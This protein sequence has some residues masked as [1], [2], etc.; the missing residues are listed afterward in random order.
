MSEE[1]RKILHM[2]AEG[3]IT[4]EEAERLLSVLKETKDRAH[5]FRVRVYD[6]NNGKTKVKVDIPLGV[7]RLLL[8]FGATFQGLAPEGFKMNIKGKEFKLD[9]FTPEMIDKIIGELDESGRFSLVEVD[10][11]ED[12]ERVEVYIE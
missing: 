6:R 3:K 10:D 7:L 4:P 5:F 9:E 12:N 11:P 1:R 8:K 2:V